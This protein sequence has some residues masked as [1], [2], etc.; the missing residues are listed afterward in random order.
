MK[1]LVLVFCLNLYFLAA[2]Q[3]QTV[4]A[5]NFPI[6]GDGFVSNMVNH[7]DAGPAGENTT[8]DF[9]GLMTTDFTGTG[10]VDPATTSNGALF[11]DATVAIN[12]G[13]NVEYLQI[14]DTEMIRI[15][16]SNSQTVI[17][18]SDG[19]V[20]LKVP[21]SFGD[22]YTDEFEAEFETYGTTFYRSGSVTATADATGTLEMPYG[23][24]DNVLRVKITES[25]QD[26]FFF[27]VSEIINYESE[28][29]A[30]YKPGIRFPVLSFS[31][32]TTND[33]PQTFS[34]GQYLESSAVSVKEIQNID[35][36]L[37]IFPN[38]VSEQLSVR[39]D[40]ENAEQIR[41][42]LLDTYGREVK[43][44]EQGQFAAGNHQSNAW[45]NDFNSGM[46]IVQLQS[47]SGVQIETIIIE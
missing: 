42:S 17:I 28:I 15:G 39:F 38:P 20:T 40:L 44:L 14:T 46:Y 7:Q 11:P 27:S 22:S 9:S 2:S 8:W 45:V 1:K 30:W 41:L 36:Q 34:F 4:T 3:A 6:I 47:E 16:V 43:V 12:Q 19:E 25:Y 24:V 10:V 23:T 31:T 26:S 21:T 33:P 18:Y 32:L 37:S 5:A 13:G 29:Y 35:H